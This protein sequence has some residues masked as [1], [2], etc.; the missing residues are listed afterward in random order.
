VA[1]DQQSFTIDN[2]LTSVVALGAIYAIIDSKLGKKK[3]VD[4]K[5]KE[6]EAQARL[7]GINDERIENMQKSID[8]AH[9][10][11]RNVIDEFNGVNTTVAR[12]KDSIEE[13][14]RVLRKIET[15][16]DRS[17]IEIATI[18]ERIKDI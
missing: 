18:Q 5:I 13:Q 2:I 11:I 7:N 8:Q 14:T 10:K 16:I 12:I 6:K 4:E 15:Y 17:S 1:T 3:Y 9:E